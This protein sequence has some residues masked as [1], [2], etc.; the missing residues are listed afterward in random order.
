MVASRYRRVKEI[1]L[2]VHALPPTEQS[3][4]LE[5][6][7][8]GDAVLRKE[9]ASLLAHHKD[10]SILAEPTAQEYERRIAQVTFGHGVSAKWREEQRWFLHQRVRTW[11]LVLHLAIALVLFRALGVFGS[12]P[13]LPVGSKVGII[14]ACLGVSCLSI[15][16]LAVKSPTYA[17]LRRMEAALT[18]TAMTMLWSFSYGWL[19]RGVSLSEPPDAHL[20]TLLQHV[21]WVVSPLRTSHFQLGTAL[22][23]FPVTNHWSLLGGFYGFI[24]PNTLRRNCIVSALFVL[25]AGTTILVAAQTNPDLRPY[26]M[27]NLISCSVTICASAGICSFVGREFQALRR[28][29]FDAKQVGQYQLTRLLGQGGMG[30]VFLAQHR[31]LRR[32]CAVKLIHPAQAGSKEVLLRFEREVQAMAQLTHPNTVEIYDFGRT[33]DDSFFYAMEYL[34]GINLDALVC[35]HG[36]QCAGR[37]VYLLGQMC[38]AL[39]EAHN[40][41]LVHRDIKPGNIFICERGGLR[42]VIKLLDF[43]LVHV[44]P[45]GSTP[46]LPG[47]EPSPRTAAEERKL[48]S[49]AADPARNLTHAG[50]ILGTPAYMAPEQIEGT[51]PD[52]RSDIYSLGG[53]AC[54]LLTGRPPFEREN[55]EEL[56]AAHVSA[57][58]PRLRTP[59]LDIPEDLESVIMRCLAKAPEARYQSVDELAAALRT[60]A[61]YGTW[62]DSQAKVWWQTHTLPGGA[63]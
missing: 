63:V 17:W 4:A 42:D 11:A 46:L 44:Q 47:D 37:V 40:K 50:Q 12:W 2:A 56:Y 51:Q 16:A 5:K 53:V 18:G 21:H 34:P 15:G 48:S 24:I 27:T 8:A 38:S 14:G 52:A 13:K 20:Q 57:P 28:A 9:V 7:C 45:Q 43:G 62:D 22:L 55:L 10:E 26:V 30:E 33:D 3:A 39:A 32:P 23:S 29:V 58:V 61:C 31:L 25:A 19:S 41:G 1:F 6:E 36:S 35:I 60:T 54:F 59:V 49:T